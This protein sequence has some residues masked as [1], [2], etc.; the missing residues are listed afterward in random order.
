VSDVL[1]GLS[2]LTARQRELVE[3]WLPGLEVEADL[4]WGLV[5][6]TV[7]KVAARGRQYVVKAGGDTDHHL[8]REL[9]AHARWLGPWRRAGRGPV[10]V[11]GDAAAKVLVTEY[12]PGRLVQDDPAA[13]DLD[14]YVQAGRLLALL[15]GQTSVEDAGYESRANA[16]AE[17]WLAG[18]H[19]IDPDDV[20]RLRALIRSWPTATSVLVPTHGDWQGRNWLVDDDGTVRVIDL[21]RADLRPAMTD[22]DRLATR[23]FRRYPGAE[24]A[25]LAGYGADPREPDAWFRS[26]VREAIGT[27]AWAFQVGDEAFE[28]EGHRRVADVLAEVG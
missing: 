7:L 9:R 21:G 11:H 14:T 26:R 12:L 27:A 5:E 28:A 18:E 13:A 10:L 6:T 16:K 19:R 25:F 24:D 22:L 3:A 2:G 4:S 23:E 20:E 17:R 15:H 8:A 1:A